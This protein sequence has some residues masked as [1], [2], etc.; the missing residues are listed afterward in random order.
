MPT[1]NHEE[2]EEKLKLKSKVSEIRNTPVLH[3][4][5]L[6]TNPKSAFRN[7]KSENG[8]KPKVLSVPS[9]ILYFFLLLMKGNYR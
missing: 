1:L 9:V 6:F 5:S 2:H 7:P 8:L 4:S 3:C